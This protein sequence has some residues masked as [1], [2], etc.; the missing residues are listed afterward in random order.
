M[1]RATGLLFGAEFRQPVSHL[2][3]AS[4]I[5]PA[6]RRRRDGLLPHWHLRRQRGPN[7]SIRIPSMSPPNVALALQQLDQEIAYFNANTDGLI[8]DVMRNPGGLDFLCGIARAAVHPHAVPHRRLR[9][10]RHGSLALLLCCAA[11]LGQNSRTPLR[12]SSRTC[13]TTST[14]F[15][16]P[17]TR[18]A[19]A[20]RRCR[21]TPPEA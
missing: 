6:P 9:N 21:S 20:A 16:G 4:G 12:K 17:T 10:P 3:A 15:S 7:R 19:D 5:R 1:P 13:R 14:R 2:R 11:D 18:I 8:V